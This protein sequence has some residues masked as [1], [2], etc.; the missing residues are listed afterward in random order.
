LYHLAYGKHSLKIKPRNF[1]IDLPQIKA[2]LGIATPGIFQFVIASGSWIYLAHLVA[3]TGGDNGSAGYQT[4]LRLMMFFML[5]AWGLSNAVATLV[6]QN[7]GAGE[8]QRAHD[9]VMTTVKYNVSFSLAVTAIFFLFGKWMVSFFTTDPE[10][11]AVAITAMRIMSVGFIVYALGM[12]MINTFNGA[13]DTWTPTYV[14][15]AGFWLFQMPLAWLL[16]MHLKMGPEGVF[17]AIPVAETG[18]SIASFILFKRG[19]WKKIKV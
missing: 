13:G 19:K 14:N 15:L 18:I 16:A 4:A 17:I 11:I 3:V 6:G 1:I 2:L 8:L 9:S 10:V 7:L 12:V 5:P